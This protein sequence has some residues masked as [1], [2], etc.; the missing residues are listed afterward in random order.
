[1]TNLYYKGLMPPT[2]YC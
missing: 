2:K 1:M